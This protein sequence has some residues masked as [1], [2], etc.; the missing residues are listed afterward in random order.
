MQ[1]RVGGNCKKHCK[2]NISMQNAH[3][4]TLSVK[5]FI[6][7]KTFASYPSRTKYCKWFHGSSWFW[8]YYS[9]SK[10]WFECFKSISYWHTTESSEKIFCLNVRSFCGI[11]IYNNWIKRENG[12]YGWRHT[13][14]FCRNSSTWWLMKIFHG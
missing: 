10:L 1:Q 13:I 9:L 3:F 11:V 14:T 5:R 2:A 7:L 8:K 4:T 6:R 12:V